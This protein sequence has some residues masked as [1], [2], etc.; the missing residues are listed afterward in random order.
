MWSDRFKRTYVI[1]YLYAIYN[2]VVHFG[3]SMHFQN[4][5]DDVHYYHTAIK[6]SEEVFDVSQTILD[7]VAD[8]I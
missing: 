1:C 8:K 7:L 3:Y 4:Y 2:H 5:F 6:R